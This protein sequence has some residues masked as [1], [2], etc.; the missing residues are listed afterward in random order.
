M[1]LII[2]IMTTVCIGIAAIVIDVGAIF[3]ERRDLQ[4][5]A[6]AAA[7]AVA[8]DCALG[9][10]CSPAAAQ[11]IAEQY[12]DAN[13][14]DGQARV[15]ENEIVFGD[16]EVTV[17]T[18]TDDADGRDIDGNPNT[19]D[20]WFARIWGNL[21]KEVRAEATAR[22]GAPGTV[23]AIPIVISSCEWS[24]A[25][26]GGITFG[27]GN[28]RIIY[29]HDLNDSGG[30]GGGNGGGSGGQTPPLCKFGPGQDIDGDGER[31]EGGFGYLESSGC[32]A[33]ITVGGYVTGEPGAG[34]PGSLGCSITDILGQDLL[35][36]IFDDASFDSANPCGGPPG[37]NCYHIYGF[38]AFHVSDVDLTG[39]QWSNQSNICLPQQRC[40]GGYF[41][42]FVE[43]GEGLEILNEGTAPDLGVSVVVLSG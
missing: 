14:N 43:L 26:G 1:A 42:H 38:G 29:L 8:I 28:Y 25:T 17:T 5:G 9:T 37:Q 30:N 22:W 24:E 4:N 27:S 21:G 40:L 13:A 36:P 16:N 34:N 35:I 19:V 3:E 7:L 33:T 10:N 15:L 23:N 31:A 18:R 32:S 6:D 12:A 41:T 2:A 20:H 39:G 11:P